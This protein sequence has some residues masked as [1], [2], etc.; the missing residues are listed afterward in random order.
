M[1]LP[2]QLRVGLD[3]QSLPAA[4][5]GEALCDVPDG[6]GDAGQR[7]AVAEGVPR[8]LG[9]DPAGCLSEVVPRVTAALPSSPPDFQRAASASFLAVLRRELLPQSTFT[10]TFLQSIL[11]SVDS[12]DPG[13][14]ARGARGSG[15][16]TV[17][18]G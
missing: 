1:P 3:G 15:A 2:L 14:G 18:T 5:G 6:A 10:Q 9:S 4:E 17:D 12:N 16:E 7:A 11:I 8:L 13:E